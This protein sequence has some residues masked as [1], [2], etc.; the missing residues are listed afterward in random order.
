MC[1]ELGMEGGSCSQLW[2]CVQESA[3]LNENKT[4]ALLTS[5]KLHKAAESGKKKL[6]EFFPVS[7]S[8]GKIKH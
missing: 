2:L 4:A 5:L 8:Q 1:Q 7:L 3:L 6:F